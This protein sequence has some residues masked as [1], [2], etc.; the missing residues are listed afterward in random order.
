M[1]IQTSPALYHSCLQLAIN[2]C[3]TVTDRPTYSRIISGVCQRGSLQ[4][5]TLDIEAGMTI[6]ERIWFDTLQQA[7]R[8]CGGSYGTRSNID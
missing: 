7:F 1:T 2:T 4:V 5:A 6:T 8:L 3:T